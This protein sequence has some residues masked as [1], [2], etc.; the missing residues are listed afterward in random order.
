[1]VLLGASTGGPAALAAVLTT[2]AN[3]RVTPMVLIV[4]HVGPQFAEGLASWLT[5]Q[6]RFEVA[7]AKPG[8]RPTPGRALLA[9]SND[10]L[11]LNSTGA[12]HYVV[13]PADYP[14]RPSVDVLFSSVAKHGPENGVAVL[15]TGMGADGAVGLGELRKRGWM[16]IAESKESCVVFGMPKA[17]IDAGA[18]R[19]VLPADEIGTA[20]VSQ[21]R[22]GSSQAARG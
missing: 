9:S 3:E 11:V 13:E 5:N 12:L 10:H 16:T 18:A 14:Y 7:L 17:A 20:V 8:D 6:T 19:R 2:L 15:L 1:M 21:I 4:Q 22:F